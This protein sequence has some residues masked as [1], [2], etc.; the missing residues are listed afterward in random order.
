[1]NLL[2]LGKLPLTLYGLAFIHACMLRNSML[3]E[4][5]YPTQSRHPWDTIFTGHPEVAKQ[6]APPRPLVCGGYIGSLTAVAYHY[7][8]TRN[9][10]S[11]ILNRSYTK[12]LGVTRFMPTMARTQ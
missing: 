3:A 7:P 5:F 8:A 12:C 6:L 10:Q 9:Q 4:G 2:L 11:P 1:M